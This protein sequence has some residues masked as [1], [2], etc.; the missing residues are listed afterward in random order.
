MYQCA[1]TFTQRLLDQASERVQTLSHGFGGEVPKNLMQ[2]ESASHNLRTASSS[3]G[4]DSVGDEEEAHEHSQAGDAER[5][6]AAK[7]NLAVAHVLHVDV[8]VEAEGAVCL[9]H[10]ESDRRLHVG[11][12]SWAKALHVLSVC[13]TESR[14]MLVGTGQRPAKVGL[15]VSLS[16]HDSSRHLDAYHANLGTGQVGSIV[17]VSPDGKRSQVLWPGGVAA[18]YSTGEVREYGELG[19]RL[20]RLSADALEVSQIYIDAENMDGQRFS[21]TRELVAGDKVVGIDGVPVSKMPGDIARHF[22]ESISVGPI[23]SEV[24]L[25]CLDGDIEDG[26]H[27]QVHCKRRQFGR[28]EHEEE[29]LAK[30]DMHPMGMYH[31]QK[32]GAVGGASWSDTTWRSFKETGVVMRHTKVEVFRRS[33]PAAALSEGLEGADLLNALHAETPQFATDQAAGTPAVDADEQWL[34]VQVGKRVIVETPVNEL[35]E[36]FF[37]LLRNEAKHAHSVHGMLKSSSTQ[38]QV[39]A[40][41]SDVLNNDDEVGEEAKLEAERR[42]ERAEVTATADQLQQSAGV[43][44]HL[45]ATRLKLKL[46]Y[47]NAEKRPA[48]IMEGGVGEVLGGILEEIPFTIDRL[49]DTFGVNKQKEVKETNHLAKLQRKGWEARIGRMVAELELEPGPLRTTQRLK[50]LAPVDQLNLLHRIKSGRIVQRFDRKPFADHPAMHRAILTND[51]DTLIKLLDHGS[52]PE[53]GSN[54]AD[55]L[56]AFQVAVLTGNL[57]A[58]RVMLQAGAD[59]DFCFQPHL[60][61]HRQILGVELQAMTKIQQK[62]DVNLIKIK[63]L[64]DAG[65]S[66]N[67]KL[68]SD[69]ARLRQQQLMHQEVARK[70]LDQKHTDEA[71]QKKLNARAPIALACFSKQPAMVHELLLQ[72][73]EC[74]IGLPSIEAVGVHAAPMTL[75]QW[76]SQHFLLGAAQLTKTVPSMLQPFVSQPLFGVFCTWVHHVHHRRELPAGPDSEAPDEL[77]GFKVEMTLEELV[78]GLQR[79]GLWP[80]EASLKKLAVLGVCAEGSD[81]VSD[82]GLPTIF[83]QS[84]HYLVSKKAAATDER[85]AAASG[86][87]MAGGEDD[88]EEELTWHRFQRVFQRKV[89]KLFFSALQLENGVGGADGAYALRDKKRLQALVAEAEKVILCSRPC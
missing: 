10:T 69:I 74:E 47:S 1:Y 58:V 75:L 46:L 80:A 8:A 60:L 2:P 59:V 52:K 24:V 89:E 44:K 17:G 72:N 5:D 29:H 83:L 19:F 73:A 30:L 26:T 86:L 54:V 21:D 11:D 33:S 16:G 78:L 31:L 38:E 61:R 13:Q 12:V 42:L 34:R 56:S 27:Y 6:R 45:E 53:Q 43:D 77:E 70:A 18:W 39:Q 35:G 28:S 20:S 65:E 64:E 62:I 67:P 37:S 25:D 32:A 55:Q 14:Q 7:V 81:P 63:D 40:L 41:L 66:E 49:L 51:T 68:K 50:V 76:C 82:N 36:A 23:D 3:T 48:P 79:F 88:E 22:R 71:F 4:S 15:R 84:L 57:D 85:R 9:Q 87:E